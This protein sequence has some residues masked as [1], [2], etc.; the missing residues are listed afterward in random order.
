MGLVN[1]V[2]PDDQLDAEVDAWCR[3]IVANSP[4]AIVIAKRSL[5]ADSDSIA[6][7]AATGMQALK[8]Y[9]DTEQSR[10]GVRPL[11]EKRKPD[12]R[13]CTK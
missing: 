4:T 6:G 10:E 13:K 9:Y 5:N 8:L 1:K 7:I 2:V 3:E 12:F 11:G